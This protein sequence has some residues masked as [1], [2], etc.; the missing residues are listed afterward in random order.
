MQFLNMISTYTFGLGNLLDQ[1]TGSSFSSHLSQYSLP[2]SGG[3]SVEH[4]ITPF[5]ENVDIIFLIKSIPPGL[6]KTCIHLWHQ[7]TPVCTL[8]L[9]QILALTLAL[10]LTLIPACTSWHLQYQ[11]PKDLLFLTFCGPAVPHILWPLNFEYLVLAIQFLSPSL[12]TFKV[13]KV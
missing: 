2:W 9:T 11:V 1:F 13:D 4:D 10:T 12:L 6:V 7:F 5:S 3:T 8:T